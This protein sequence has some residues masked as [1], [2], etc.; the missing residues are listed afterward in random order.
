LRNIGD[1]RIPTAELDNSVIFIGQ[2]GDFEPT[3]KNDLSADGW[4]YDIIGNDNSYLD[5]G[6]MLHVTVFSDKIP[7]VTGDVVIFQ[8]VLPNGVKRSTE[9]TVG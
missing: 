2:A 6:E 5:S 4:T 7:V 9:F 8:F 3:T 1:E